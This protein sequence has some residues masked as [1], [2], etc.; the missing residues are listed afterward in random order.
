MGHPIKKCNTL[1]ILNN[2]GPWGPLFKNR[3]GQNPGLGDPA[4]QGGRRTTSVVALFCVLGVRHS[5]LTARLRQQRYEESS[6]QFL[7]L[8]KRSPRP[9][10]PYFQRAKLLQ[11][12]L[13][14]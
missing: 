9:Y 6:N 1:A 4:N 11:K 8:E 10:F 12:N 14:R 7:G 3:L 13:I 2:L 5:S